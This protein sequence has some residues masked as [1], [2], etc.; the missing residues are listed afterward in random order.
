MRKTQVSYQSSKLSIVSKLQ[1]SS[2]KE[3]KRIFVK[4]RLWTLWSLAGTNKGVCGKKLKG[5]FSVKFSF[6]QHISQKDLFLLSVMIGND[7]RA[8]NGLLTNGRL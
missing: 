1:R 4:G 2:S 8:Y 3:E 5:E 6:C 7:F